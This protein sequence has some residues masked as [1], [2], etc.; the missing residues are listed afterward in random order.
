MPRMLPLRP[1]VLL[2]LGALLSALL[3]ALPSLASAGT[4]EWQP[5][6]SFVRY[7]E[8]NWA[9]PGPAGPGTVS[10]ISPGSW[11]G[12]TDTLTVGQPARG[13]GGVAAYDGGIR[14]ALPAHSIDVR[15]DDLSVDFTTGAVTASGSYVPVGGSTT[16]YTGQ[17][18]FTLTGGVQDAGAGQ[19]L[20]F[21]AVPTLTSF[22]ATVF[23]GGS[24]GSYRTGDAFGVLTA[25]GDF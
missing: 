9:G 23:N 11:N 12:T 18:L 15:I 4:V 20:W 22:G 5:R 3:L 24:F 25:V 2:L 10:A 21:D 17:Q 14:F 7:V 19:L 13:S 8:T 16:T 6:A 1:R